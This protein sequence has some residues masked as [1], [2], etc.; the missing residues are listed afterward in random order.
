LLDDRRRRAAGVHLEGGAPVAKEGA[1]SPGLAVRFWVTAPVARRARDAVRPTLAES[2]DRRILLVAGVAVLG[3]LPAVWAELAN[4]SAPTLGFWQAVQP[5]RIWA[6]LTSGVAGTL[7]EIRLVLIA[8]AAISTLLAAAAVFRPSPGAPRGRASLLMALGLLAGAGEMA[9]SSIP[10][11]RPAPAAMARAVFTA[12]ADVGHLLGAAVWV[13]GLVALVAL[14][15]VRLSASQRHA[16][17][18]AAIR[19]FSLAATISLGVM[20]LSGLWTAWIHVGSPSLLVSTPYGER[21]LV[22]LIPVAALAG[23]GSFNLLWVL[24]RVGAIHRAGDG[25]PTLPA[26][27]HHFR[28]AIVAEAVLGIA[29]LLVVPFLS[30]SARSQDFQA[31]AADLT[32]AKQ[33]GSSVVRLKPSGSQVGFTDYDVWLFGAR[34]SEV[35]LGFSSPQLGVPETDVVASAVDSDHYRVTG[36]YTPLAGQWK[37]RVAGAGAPGAVFDLK[38]FGAAPKLPKAPT[39]VVQTSTW[40]RG[41]SWVV[42]VIGPLLGANLVSQRLTARRARAAAASQHPSD[43]EAVLTGTPTP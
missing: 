31:R 25:Q 2:T 39:P 24:P 32:Q 28:R 41:V 6:F 36:L 18:P 7:W 34:T 14:V 12:V 22:K 23:L 3:F 10:K 21:L 17:W 29:I 5:G 37:V 8:V 40:V 9:V 19:R 16:F 30:G 20:I 1:A 35:R 26:I 4:E 38:V 15:F 11:T 33:A 27:M 43:S 42:A 13:G